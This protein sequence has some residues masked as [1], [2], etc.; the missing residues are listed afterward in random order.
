MG[1][2]RRAVL[3][4]GI[5]LMITG[6]LGPGPL[7]AS[8]TPAQRDIEA[9]VT[10]RWSFG[11]PADETDV[12]RL[13][14]SPEVSVRWG[15]PMTTAEEQEVDPVG[16]MAF[17]QEAKQRLLPTA[18]KLT[19]FSG[20]WFDQ[21]HDGQLVV[22]LTDWTDATL[23][24]LDHARPTFGP[25]YR[26]ERADTT[27]A[28]LEDAAA[29]VERIW[30]LV[31][32]I[33]L[34]SYA[35]D[36]RHNRLVLDVS[37]Q[38]LEAASASLPDF[39]AILGVSAVL[40]GADD[41]TDLDCNPR[42]DCY[43]LRA[44]AKVFKGALDTSSYCSLGFLVKN[45]NGSPANQWL[46]AGHCGYAGS[47]TWYNHGM[48]HYACATCGSGK[49]GV[50]QGNAYDPNGSYIRDVMRVGVQDPPGETAMA[51]R[52]ADADVTG[53]TDAEYPVE[54]EILCA[55]LGQS[56]SI[57]CGWVVSAQA[58]WQS[59][60]V[61]PHPTVH[62]ASMDTYSGHTL[63]PGDSGS[64]IYATTNPIQGVYYVV[65]VGIADSERQPSLGQYR[66]IYFAKVRW[67]VEYWNLE[68]FH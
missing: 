9:A 66:D 46:T 30:S 19:T 40:R 27:Y 26:V 44:G 13:L 17:A 60:T 48:Q 64:P 43:P 36:Q 33:R 52:V 67:A 8:G 12:A 21:R 6:I 7:S 65:P 31:A 37:P 45:W 38:D 10:A 51:A 34:L 55:S 58:S 63:N 18:Q 3:V 56:D 14:E 23:N 28:R 57:E 41:I 62:G 49:I 68:V 1:S 47:N 54:G 24:Q 15:F 2:P 20:A 32:D 39:A 5:A 16:R 42:T 29:A 50:E 4:S 25:G 35:I 59:D 11:L 53:I 22:M 61:T